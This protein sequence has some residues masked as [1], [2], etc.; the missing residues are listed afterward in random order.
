MRGNNYTMKVRNIWKRS[1]NWKIKYARLNRKGGED[2]A[3]WLQLR[4][5]A[6]ISLAIY[7]VSTDYIIIN[8]LDF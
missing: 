5:A 4:Q 2:R 3:V 6:V 1:R 8:S 7:K